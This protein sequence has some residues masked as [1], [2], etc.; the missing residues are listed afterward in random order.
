MSMK[1]FLLLITLIFAFVPMAFAGNK[2]PNEILCPQN[3]LYVVKTNMGD[4]CVNSLKQKDI[5]WTYMM[6]YLN[7]LYENFDT[8]KVKFSGRKYSNMRLYN[9]YHYI[10]HKD[11]S[12]TDLTPVVLDIPEFNEHVKNLILNY[13]PAP[14]IDGMPDE[15]KVELEITQSVGSFGG[16]GTEY[17]RGE[18]YNIHF[19]K[20]VEDIE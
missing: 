12:I 14:L 19:T 16:G 6:R 10:I 9:I 13:P 5:I 15:M 11:G 20:G 8:K 17:S 7:Y 4:I 3:C 2:N 18:Y 1:K